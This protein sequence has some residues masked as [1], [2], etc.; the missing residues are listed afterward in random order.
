[1]G[2]CQ[3]A[4]DD[5]KNCH[6]ELRNSNTRLLGAFQPRCKSDGSY[7]DKQCHGS[8]GHCWCVDPKNGREIS[9][10]RKGPGQGEVKCQSVNEDKKN[11]HQELKNSNNRLDGAF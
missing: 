8:T 3:S 4:N 6:Q 2:K 10:T 7:E 5:T 9:G 11:C 1:M